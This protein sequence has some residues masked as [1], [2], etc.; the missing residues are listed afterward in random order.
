MKKFISKDDLI[1]IGYQK[2]TAQNLVRQA[3]RI[4]V[5]RGYPFYL[6]KRLGQV[7]K[8]VVESILGCELEMEDTED[9]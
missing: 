1:A 6:N 4:M 5:Q 2:H 9:G 8:E 3:K 7:P